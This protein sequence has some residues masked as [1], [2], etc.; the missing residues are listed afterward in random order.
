MPGNGRG[1]AGLL[2]FP[3]TI[4]CPGPLPTC[5]PGSALHCS[6]KGVFPIVKM[7]PLFSGLRT[8]CALGLPVGPGLAAV[9][10]PR[11]LLH[12]GAW[13][14]PRCPRCFR[15]RGE[16]LPFDAQSAA[17]SFT[18]PPRGLM[19]ICMCLLL[20]CSLR[21]LAVLSALFPCSLLTLWP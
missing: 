19:L 5:C 16:P 14:Y 7:D 21:A 1:L 9:I 10:Q 6:L 8:S 17:F 3:T 18:P 11:G 4:T 15:G 13:F 12:S 2:S 20:F